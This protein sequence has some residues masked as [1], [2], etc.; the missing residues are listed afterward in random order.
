[1]PT[2]NTIKLESDG[3]LALIT[4]HRPEKRNAI[5]AVMIAELLDAL[6]NVESGSERVAIVTG[7]GKAFCAGMDLDALKSLATLE[8]RLGS[9]AGSGAFPSR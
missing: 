8:E 6:M 5:S 2:Y 4:L 3:A 1:M 9:F 7:A